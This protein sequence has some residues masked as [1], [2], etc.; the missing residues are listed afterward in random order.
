M[1]EN[2]CRKLV[3]SRE[4]LASVCCHS[5]SL[6]ALEEM[7]NGTGQGQ[8][9]TSEKEVLHLDTCTSVESW[10]R[11]QMAIPVQISMLTRIRWLER[12]LQPQNPSTPCALLQFEPLL[13][14]LDTSIRPIAFSKRKVLS[15]TLLVTLYLFPRC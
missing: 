14:T 9:E 6:M 1:G 12:S 4:V 5:L 7:S 10:P 11:P 3:V 15:H 13:L 8:D 2:L